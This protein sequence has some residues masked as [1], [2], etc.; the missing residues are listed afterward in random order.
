MRQLIFSVILALGLLFGAP[1]AVDA[2]GP[3][4]L[5]YEI[6]RSIEE[7]RLKLTSDEDKALAI[8]M[9]NASER[10]EE[11]YQKVQA[12]DMEN[13]LI[14]L[15]NYTD[16]MDEINA[17]EEGQVRAE[18]RTMTQEEG[19]LQAGTLDRLRLSQPEEAQARN[20]Y[21]EALQRANMGLEQHLGPPESA[22]QGPSDD[23]PKGPASENGQ[24]PTEDA[25][26]GPNEDA[27]Q[28]PTNEE[29]NN[30]VNSPGQGKP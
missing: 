16:A 20:A 8:R 13:A 9:K 6:D 30:E 11:A 1:L 14:A 28:G 21:Q 22:P 4:D 19:A 24:G 25:P 7:I 27:P 26:K 29:N 18:T 17:N 23:V 10:L 5:L 15:E 12:G 3:G 2:S